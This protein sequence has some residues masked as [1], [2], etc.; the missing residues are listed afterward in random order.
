MSFPRF[1]FTL[2]STTSGVKVI[3]EPGGWDEA[4]LKLERNE[5]YHSLVEFYDQ[6]LTF[7]GANFTEDG[8][9]DYIK[10]VEAIEGA[11][12]QI[13]IL[14]E[15]SEDEGAT[16]ATVYDGLLDI[17]TIKEIDFYKIECGIIRNDFWQKFMNRKTIPVDLA[18]I[19]DIDGNAIAGY[20][21]STLNLPGQIIRQNF[22]AFNYTI[23]QLTSTG[24]ESIVQLGT[25]DNVTL[26]E[27]EVRNDLPT[28][29][30]QGIGGPDDNPDFQVKYSG[31]YTF[32]IRVEVS[33]L[34]GGVYSS[35]GALLVFAIRVNNINIVL[36]S[37]ANFT[38]GADSS[39]VY[40]LASIVP[41]VV[42][43]SVQVYGGWGG[44]GVGDSVIIYGVQGT[45][46]PSGPS[47]ATQCSYY[48]VRAE[49]TYPDTTT[50]SFLIV[51]AAKSTL[52]KCIG[53]TSVL[54]SA[55]LTISGCDGYYAIMKGL[56]VRGYSMS[57]KP[58]QMSFDDWWNG[59]NPIFNL[60]LGYE[61]ITGTD[62]IRIENKD[63]FYDPTISINF[64]YVNFIERS[65]DSDKIF[66]S[67]EI[68]YEKWSAESASGID[69][70]QTKH[71][72][73]TRFKTVGK[74]EKQLSKFYAA[75]LG[76][77]QTRRNTAT[78]GKDWRLDDDIIIIALNRATPTAPELSE[79]YTA[80]T[81][82]L[83][84]STRY[85]S[86]L[87]PGRNF[88]RWRNLF[89]G[90]LN[91]FVGQYFTFS[92]GEGNTD[93]TSD[94]NNADCD[95]VTADEKANFSENQNILIDSDFL[96]IPIVYTFEVPLP[97][98]YYQAILANR[99]K[100]IGVSRTNSGHVACFILTMEYQITHGK[101]K[102]K[103]ILGQTTEL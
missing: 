29:F 101:A 50:D 6:P 18:G 49:T 70:P 28:S 3:S 93:M 61:T 56:H 62:Y 5:A 76:I 51:D 45:S 72:Y 16:Y 31:N 94:F 91:L 57:S 48:I 69:D 96:F 75:S 84:S 100:A 27:I 9:Y 86:R 99:T 24:V 79:N 87:T 53:R 81:N 54:N 80:I 20:S 65:Y 15:I 43:D 4:V 58:I 82:L 46:T 10:S 2:N 12:S 88:F 44:V 25:F 52:E 14:I 60:G 66:K 77:E 71:T 97:Y 64:D 30:Y 74:D 83:N 89:D 59:A 42:G 34:S 21:P 39:T 36:S 11:D 13:S 40:T 95:A 35:P 23:I 73:H 37:S 7:Y 68:G 22:S 26:D 90:C 67:I 92:A 98:T 78:I 17:T 103:V 63:Y 38:A 55:L 102:F 33:L 41:L 8:G 47:G 1:R 85:N 32:N 19:V